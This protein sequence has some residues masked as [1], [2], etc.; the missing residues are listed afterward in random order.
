[1]F[2]LH[3]KFRLVSLALATCW[4]VPG[5][6]GET[7]IAPGA[8]VAIVG[9]S[10]TEQKLYSKFIETYLLACS[11]V[12]KVEVFQFGWSGETAGGFA[13]RLENDLAAFKPTVVTLCYGMNDGGYQ[14]YRE[15]IGQGYE[16]NMRSILK[17]LEGIGVKTVVVGSPGA[18]DTDFFRPG[19]MM[20]DQPSHVAYN[21]NLA[22][23]RDIDKKLAAEFKQPFADVH[24]AMIDAMKKAKAELGKGYDVCGR[25]GFHPGSNGQLIMAYAF[26]KA[27]ELDGKIGEIII[28]MKG[29]ATASDGHQVL[30][31]K[32]GAAEIE[33]KR[34]PFC[35]E[36]DPKSS[37]GTQSITPFLP[38]NQELNRFVLKVKN[39][40]APKAKVTWGGATQEFTQEQLA[41]GI[42]L[43]AEFS[44]TPFNPAFQKFTAAIAAKQALE[45]VMIKQVITNF[46]GIP[47]DVRQEAEVTGA[48]KTLTERL[49]AR[50]QTLEESA[51][52]L[53][54][55]V[56][57]SLSVVRVK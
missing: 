32:A 19:T 53:L 25:D 24:A 41:E 10:I 28:D 9:D 16:N 6:R 20:G 36:G 5:A 51:R 1:M 35:F 56:K 52:A 50:R 26:L 8:R 48:L 3:S 30:T 40:D 11:G 21:D 57:H 34:W 27:M 37:G 7:A 38:F 13:N 22:H 15:Q 14:P 23:L 49:M 43:A 55:P 46:R 12:P 44:T 29:E 47:G 17:K 4:L 45:T 33:S 18:V 39:L 42:N 2:D 31:S 54:T